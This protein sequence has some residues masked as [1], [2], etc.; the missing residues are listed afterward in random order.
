[1]ERGDFEVC[2]LEVLGQRDWGLTLIADTKGG[3]VP[4]G[5]ISAMNPLSTRLVTIAD[6]IWFPWASHRNCVESAVNFINELRDDFTIMEYAD[7]REQSTKRF[8]ENLC[9]YGIM[10]R[11]GTVHDFYGPGSSAALYQSRRRKN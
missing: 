5:S 10:R 3:R 8:F 11:V 7:E 1:M 4:V 6:I 2:L 9:M